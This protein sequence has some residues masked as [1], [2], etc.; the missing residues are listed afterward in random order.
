MEI[1]KKNLVLQTSKDVNTVTTAFEQYLRDSGWKTQ[2]RVEEGQAVL[3]ANKLGF[4]RDIIAADRALTFMFKEN[5]G[6]LEVHVGVGKLGQNL[7]VTAIE[8]L[9]L[10]DLF[11]AVD[12]PEMLWTK[13]VETE[14][15]GQLKALAQ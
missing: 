11:I 5:A 9:L 3:Q 4:L 2:S 6:N 15:L 7:A 8:F 14:L 1:F 10:S 12:V 13:H